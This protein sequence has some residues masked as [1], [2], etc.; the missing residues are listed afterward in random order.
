MVR[1]LGLPGSCALL[2]PALTLDG[3]LRSPEVWE[4]V[5]EPGTVSP[6]W[7]L[8]LAALRL[9]YRVP[10]LARDPRVLTAVTL[11]VTLL[12]VLLVVGQVS[13][14]R[15][16]RL[17]ALLTL[18]SERGRY[19]VLATGGGI[20]FV[21]IAIFRPGAHLSPVLVG[22]TLFGFLLLVGVTWI[23]TARGAGRS[24]ERALAQVAHSDLRFHL[25]ESPEAERR[26]PDFYALLRFMDRDIRRWELEGRYPFLLGAGGGGVMTVRVPVGFDYDP[27]APTSTRVACFKRTQLYGVSVYDRAEYR[28]PGRN[29]RLTGHPAFDRT[30]VVESRSEQELL[31][32]L[33]PSV[34][35]RLLSRGSV[36]YG[37]RAD[38]FGVRVYIRDRALEAEEIRWWLDTVAQV[39]LQLQP[40]RAG[41]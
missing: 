3:V 41:G 7:G 18:R 4:L 29:V 28:R 1:W 40:R 26:H 8:V 5:G 15:P 34:C 31:A 16:G 24:L 35:E 30:F 21:A 37:L 32:V 33:T 20:I 6:I 36:G 14:W 39:A 12:V 13:G 2:P 22:R 25:V 23:L 10:A 38:G 11:L 17:R 19:V 27:W 9:T